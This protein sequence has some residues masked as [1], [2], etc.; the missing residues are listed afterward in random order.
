MV[1]IKRLSAC[2]L[3]EAVDAWNRG[4]AGYYT[5]VTTTLDKFVSRMGMED[6]SPSLSFVAFVD[7]K[8]AGLVLN[9]LRTVNGSK[10]SWNGGTCV[11]DEWR[12]KGVGAA[13][14]NATLEALRQ[15]GVALATL[16]AFRQNE[17]AVALYRK[18]GYETVDRLLFL[19]RHDPF[20]LQP[21]GA[22]GQSRYTVQR[23]TPREAG[24][25]PFYRSQVPWQ[26]QWQSA[27]EG[28][29][30]VVRSQ[31]GVTVGYALYKRVHDQAGRL[32]TIFLLQCEASPEAGHAEE[33]VRLM[34]NE[35]FAPHDRICRRSTFN[36]PASNRLLVQLL[37]EAGFRPS[38]EQVYMVKPIMDKTVPPVL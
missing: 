12:G 22:I 29:A 16:E 3:E 25:L 9:G 11:A 2:T 13:L 7:G 5:N 30:L 20:T 26:T 21:F 8:P 14:M 31:E 36:L 37:E 28:E 32:Q 27:R 35:V 24:M 17:R 23:V 38:I 34:L 4:F 6:L 1:T 19:E 18:F 33:I 10:V 15:E